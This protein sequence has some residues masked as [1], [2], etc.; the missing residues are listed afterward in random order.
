MYYND[1]NE[2]DCEMCF[3]REGDFL[4]KHRYINQ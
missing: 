2:A 3:D 1:S 4:A